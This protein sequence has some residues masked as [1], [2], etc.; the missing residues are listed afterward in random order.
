V[1]NTGDTPLANVNIVDDQEG[2]ITDLISGDINSNNMLDIDE[3]WLLFKQ[4]IAQTGQYTNYVQAE[5][6]AVDGTGTP[7]LDGTGQPW[8]PITDDDISHYFGAEP[9]LA[10]QTAINGY[11]PVAPPGP[12]LTMGEVV[13]W[14]YTITNSGNVSFNQIDVSGHYTGNPTSDPFGTMIPTVLGDDD[15]DAILDVGETWTYVLNRTIG[16]DQYIAATSLSANPI[17]NLGNPILSLGNQTLTADDTLYYIGTRPSLQLAM[18]PNRQN[19]DAIPGP[20]IL[21]DEAIVWTY[22][23]ANDGTAPLANVT[24]IDD[25]LGAIGNQIGGDGNGNGLLDIGE[26]WTYEIGDSATAGQQAPT[27]QVTAQP[28]L[29]N[30]DPLT[31]LDGLPMPSTTATTTAFYYGATVAFEF[32][33]Q[34]DDQYD[35]STPF[36][37]VGDSFEWTYI[38]TNSGNVPLESLQLTDDSLFNNGPTNSA[39]LTMLS[40]SG[41]SNNN[42]WLDPNEVWTW[43]QEESV[44]PNQQTSLATLTATPMSADGGPI[45]LADNS[46]M[47]PMVAQDSQPYFGATPAL[48][49]VKMAN[50]VVADT[51]PGLYLPTGDVINWGYTLTN[52][53]N[54]SLSPINLSNSGTGGVGPPANGDLNNN[55]LLDVGE[56]WEYETTEN[57]SSGPIASLS[58]FTSRP[59]DGAGNPIPPISVVINQSQTQYY[60][61]VDTQMVLEGRVNGEDADNGLGLIIETGETLRWT[62]SALASA[63]SS[64]TLFCPQTILFAGEQMECTA[65][66]VALAGAQEHLATV[67]A[68]PADGQDNSLVAIA[69]SSFFA[70]QASDSTRYFGSDIEIDLEKATNG[71]DADSPSGPFIAVG[72]TVTWTYRVTNSGNWTLT[73]VVLTDQTEISPLLTPAPLLE[74]GYNVGDLNRD[75]RLD[76]NET[77]L[78]RATATAQLGMQ[79]STATVSAK[80]LATTSQL[81]GSPILNQ[82]VT[83]SDMSH[84]LGSQPGIEVQKQTNGRDGDDA[85]GIYIPVGDAVLWSYEVSS[86]GNSSIT[87][88]VLT[89]TILVDGQEER[90]ETAA[91]IGNEPTFNIGDSNLNGQLDKNEVWRYTATAFPAEAGPSETVATVTG[92]P[93]DESGNPLSSEPLQSSDPSHYF[94]AAPALMLRYFAGD[95]DDSTAYLVEAEEMVLY[96]FIVENRGNM[97][98]KNLV[99]LDDNGTPD[100]ANDDFLIGS[101]QCNLLA[102]PLGPGDTLQCQLQ[103]EVEDDGPAQISLAT[104]TGTPVDQDNQAL[105]HILRP[106][107][108]A[109]AEIAPIAPALAVEYTIYTG[110]DDGTNCPGT[111]QLFSLNVDQIT[112]CYQATNRGNTY[113]D[114]LRLLDDQGALL[115]THNQLLAPNQSFDFFVEEII[116]LAVSTPLISE[117]IIS[118]SVTAIG[119]PSR[120]SG[121]YV[122]DGPITATD[123]V[124][125]Y[126][127]AVHVGGIVWYDDDG[128]GLQNELVADAMPNGGVQDVIAYLMDGLTGDA[129]LDVEGEPLQQATDENG[130]YLFD[131]LSPG[132]YVVRFDLTTLPDGYKPTLSHEEEADSQSLVDSETGYAATTGIL[133][134][135]EENVSIHLGLI[136]GVEIGGLVWV[137]KNQDG[138]QDGVQLDK[139]TGLP[140][141]DEEG[142][143]MTTV[144]DSEG[145]YLFAGLPTGNYAVQLKAESIPPLYLY[146]SLER[147]TTSTLSG[148]QAELDLDFGLI[149]TVELSGVVWYD[150][151]SDGLQDIVFQEQGVLNVLVTLLNGDTGTAILGEDG[152]PLSVRT[153][154]DGLYRFAHLSP[155]H[156]AVLF[157]LE[158]LPFGFMPTLPDVNVGS[159]VSLHLS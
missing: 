110:H 77:W 142:A 64:A 87:D 91:V 99:I 114:Q 117:Q 24:L 22:M 71:T 158:T 80:P 13:T 38:I 136:K 56:T 74:A 41:D 159:G 47:A 68:I 105:A 94:G 67:S 37:L 15:N 135:G 27:A 137:D 39:A 25:A 107:A 51:A 12:Y 28:V 154:I 100:N 70:H 115:V 129:I 40:I 104:A 120:G 157:D 102:G 124:E 19:A 144:T 58:T 111:T 60:F 79:A 78:Y 123:R 18:R 145:H 20:T 81:L 146:D 132:D 103:K 113:L 134:G 54:V 106:T 32:D 82:T 9:S 16:Y 55:G 14:T 143:A 89:D 108:R 92:M 126:Q 116:D 125:I 151:D 153:D 84:Y 121:V 8:P 155:G 59:V 133:F 11:R 31:G 88:I 93:V 4:G 23:V 72:S 3:S 130:H 95:A 96:T 150:N 49:M 139:T 147:I 1:S 156:Y 73:D 85:P 98:L 109:N 66:T 42:N 63:G 34:M 90:I 149:E 131:D 30:G 29:P 118:R 50:G 76:A 83:D 128:N 10:F 140:M 52:I 138:V 5:S 101:S 53:G 36:A 44:K 86:R 127:E 2:A 122:G 21:A 48:E 33:K 65:E 35:G 97:A 62:D 45:L 75:G 112:H 17:D 152:R 46:E 7:L 119:V 57:A 148:S 6:T 69:P 43:T 141:L 26:F 61:G